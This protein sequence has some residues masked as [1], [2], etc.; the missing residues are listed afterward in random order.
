MKSQRS[1][2]QAWLRATNEF[3]AQGELSVD[4]YIELEKAGYPK[5]LVDNYIQGRVAQAAQVEASAHALVG[6]EEAY[7][8]M[9]TW[10]AENLSPNEVTAFNNAVEDPA[11]VEF[12]VRSLAARYKAE[13]DVQPTNEIRGGAAG[14]NNEAPFATKEEYVQA[15]NQKMKGSHKKLY[16][17]NADYRAQV[18]RRLAKSDFSLM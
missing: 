18:I 11:N 5:T 7:Q 8:S 4:T 3:L 13:A 16:E 17:T 2:R 6:G 12:A 14:G 15:C 1:T 10:A 9:L